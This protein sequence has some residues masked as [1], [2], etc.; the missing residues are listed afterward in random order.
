ME[1]ISMPIRYI[2]STDMIIPLLLAVISYQPYRL[3]PGEKLNLLTHF[4]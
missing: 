1:F 3:N 2:E 4:H